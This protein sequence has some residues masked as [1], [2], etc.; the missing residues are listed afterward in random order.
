MKIA[1]G[2]S[3]GVDSSV[4]ALLLKKAGHDVLGLS[5]KLW[6]APS[7]GATGGKS[8]C[9]G[10]DEEEDLRAAEQV[11]SALGIPFHVFDC[12]EDYEQVVL[13]NFRREYLAGRT[14]NPCVRCNPMVKF[15]VLPDA[16]R[17]SGLVFDRFATGHYARIEFDV[18]AGRH[19]LK[20]GFDPRKDQSYF[21]YRLTQAQLASTV[22]PLGG[23]LKSRVREIARAEGL[24]VHDHPESQD[25]YGGD[26]ADLV[27]APAAEGE[28]VDGRGNVLGRHR[29]IWHYTIGQR[30]GLGLSSAVPRYVIEIDAARNRI[31]VGPES[32]TLRRSCVAADCAW[33]A[34][35]RPTAQ[36]NVAVKI[37]S[38]SR[39][40]A[41][42]I[43]PLDG[44]RVRVEFAA[45]LSAVT[46]GQ[47]AVF[48]QD[49]VVVGG[50]IIDS[51]EA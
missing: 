36:M 35:E 14:P 13:D 51:A 17:R 19:L 48:Y 29:G 28:I 10:P 18:S 15:G 46:P 11:S 39:P 2:M 50:G 32:E 34:V 4:A 38:G 43:A 49:D 5:M 8:A 22:F 42:E 6:R 27:G 1:V 24:P 3:G 45:P 16:A 23:L 25:F 37:R 31:V 7:A 40:A 9:F 21:L 41:A 30:K 12:S 47:S 33:I 20:K 44:E 26:W